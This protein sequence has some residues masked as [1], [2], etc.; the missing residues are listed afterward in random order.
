MSR[1]KFVKEIVDQA[2]DCINQSKECINSLHELIAMLE[3][4]ETEP[5][6]TYSLEEVRNV[7]ANLSRNGHTDAV[8]EA[9][10]RQGGDKLSDLDPSKYGELMKD[11]EG[12]G[13]E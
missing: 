8:R 1:M 2:K 4:N 13:H 11:V 3:S 6:K 5:E 7:L 10:K 12:I 9:I